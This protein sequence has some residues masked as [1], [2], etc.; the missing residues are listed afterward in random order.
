MFSSHLVEWRRA[1][2]VGAEALRPAARPEKR[3]AEHVE[4]AQL[5]GA[6]GTRGAR[7]GQDQGGA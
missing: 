2:D 6:G 1:R 5:T 3:T 4:I 7:A